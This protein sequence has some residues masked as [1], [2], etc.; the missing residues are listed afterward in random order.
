MSK[1]FSEKIVQKISNEIRIVRQ[2]KKL[3]QENVATELGIS[4]TAYSKIERG[5]THLSIVRLQQI[6]ECLGVSLV[7]LMA[8][9][10]DKSDQGKP[11]IAILQNKVQKLQEQVE[12]LNKIITDKDIIINLLIEKIDKK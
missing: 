5:L 8:T 4:L 7:R 3:N 1:D 12:Q 2:A 6:A 10:P 11:S 9:L